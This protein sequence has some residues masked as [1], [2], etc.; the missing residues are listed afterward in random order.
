[1]WRPRA[2]QG[3]LDL[4][5]SRARWACRPPFLVATGPVRNISAEGR[6]RATKANQGGQ[7]ARLRANIWPGEGH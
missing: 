4:R 6:R 3:G 2:E 1:M 5:V 7:C